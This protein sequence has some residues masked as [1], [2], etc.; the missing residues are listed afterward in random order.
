MNIFFRT[1]ASH[2]IGTGHVMR[3]LTLAK[4]LIPR[5]V[6]CHFICRSH[7]GH[8]IEYL[9][10][11]DISV[12]VL[13]M[14]SNANISSALTD[15]DQWLGAN[16]EDDVNQT[17]D[18]F[19][20]LIPDWLVVDH[21]AI[22]KNWEQ[23]LRPY[24]KNIMVIDDLADRT[25]DCDLLLDQNLGSN[26]EDYQ[27]LVPEQSLVFFGPEYALLRPEFSEFRER[28]IKRRKQPQM[29]HIIISMGGTDYPNA[30]KQVLEALRSCKLHF[31]T[32]ITIILGSN[33]PWI[34][35]VKCEIEVLQKEQPWEVNLLYNVKNIAALLT[36]CDLVIGAAGSSCWERCCLGVPSI[37]IVT[38][39]NQ[40]NIAKALDK[41][42]AAK[43]ISLVELHSKSPSWKETMEFEIHENLD[44]LSNNSLKIC[45]GTGAKK[46]RNILLEE[47]CNI[48]R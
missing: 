17:I 34:E 39:D 46:V 31:D 6:N 9:K 4:T 7:E 14:G 22:E 18:A 30:T 35:K 1:D 36:E 33:A 27:S 28:S 23:K 8:L 42:N 2:L 44:S 11:N 47:T 12:K 41:A 15:H 16:W 37:I 3:C 48:S 32:K 26:R 5:G 10:Q 45:D 40:K 21:Y 13:P 43:V 38:A 24:C 29:K 20:N 19:R 25:H